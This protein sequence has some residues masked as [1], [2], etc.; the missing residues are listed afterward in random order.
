M[1]DINLLPEESRTKD[2]LKPASQVAVKSGPG[3][4]Q[5]Q[6]F[7]YA[8][9][10]VLGVFAL[11]HFYLAF[12]AILKN[13]KLAALSR[14]WSQLEPQR[15][16]FDTFNQE[17]SVNSQDGNAAL[18]LTNQRLLWAQKINKLSLNLPAGVWFNDIAINPKV[19]TI[20]G[21]VV[22]LQKEEIGL[23]NK[24]SENLKADAEFS[25]DFSGFELSN[26]QKRS[27]GGYDIADFVLV[28]NIKVK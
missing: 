23:I 12:N 2:K 28:G 11:V 17:F 7:I 22:S 9:P 24:L 20:Q 16:T 19:M 6:L 1:I 13:G 18:V 15:K 4:N 10:V 27:V 21:S 14:K 26:I 5:D 25:R 3:F 8:I